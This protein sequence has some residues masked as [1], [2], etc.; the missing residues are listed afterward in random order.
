MYGRQAAS[1]SVLFFLLIPKLAD[2]C[3]LC[4][5]C[6]SSIFS[7]SS[8]LQSLRFTERIKL[9]F[10][11]EI[12][13]WSILLLSFVWYNKYGWPT[14]FFLCQTN[15]AARI[16]NQLCL[17]LEFGWI[18][19]FEVNMVPIFLIKIQHYNIRIL[20]FKKWHVKNFFS[21]SR[22]SKPIVTMKII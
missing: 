9:F 15:L 8:C 5:H 6:Y 16:I 10:S 14:N 3:W 11:T 13:G 7:S 2:P 1:R 18:V 22:F 19:E 20:V 17:Y 21:F 4:L 12:I